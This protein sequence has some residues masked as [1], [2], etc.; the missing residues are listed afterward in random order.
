MLVLAYGLDV[1]V[2]W[3]PFRL[4]VVLPLMVRLECGA[5]G[6]S[7]HADLTESGGPMTS[8]LSK[9]SPVHSASMLFERSVAARPSELSGTSAAWPGPASA[10]LLVLLLSAIRAR[11]TSAHCLAYGSCRPDYSASC[12]FS[13]CSPIGDA[14]AIGRLRRSLL[15]P[16]LFA[17]QACCLPMPGTGAIVRTQ[18]SVV[19]LVCLVTV[20]T[21]TA[22]RRPCCTSSLR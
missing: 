14:Q 2:V 4:D 5:F 1:L 20:H 21:F 22:F 6:A 18:P 12:R 15:T 10:S 13:R 8:R 3:V 17:S 11:M 7:G 16:V 19:R 9:R